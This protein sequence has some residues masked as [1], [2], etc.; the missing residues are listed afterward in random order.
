[1]LLECEM[2]FLDCF[3]EFCC[4][5]RDF[6]CCIG[7]KFLEMYLANSYFRDNGWSLAVD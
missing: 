7:P 5:I 1:M 6:M 2:G 3:E 4:W